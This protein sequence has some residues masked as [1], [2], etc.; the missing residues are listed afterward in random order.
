MTR[1]GFKTLFVLVI[2]TRRVSFE[3]VLMWFFQ[4]S[5]SE[6][7]PTLTSFLTGTLGYESSHLQRVWARHGLRCLSKG[8]N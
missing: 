2:V 4:R 3:V 1:N 6:V 5:V 8:L 7:K